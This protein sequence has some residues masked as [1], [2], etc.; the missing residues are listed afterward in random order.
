MTYVPHVR[1][2]IA[3]YVCIYTILELCRRNIDI[4]IVDKNVLRYLFTF[5][6]N[7]PNLT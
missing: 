1:S 3:Y 2:S 6:Y 4:Q 7:N 5:I